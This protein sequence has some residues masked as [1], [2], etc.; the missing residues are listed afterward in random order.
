MPRLPHENLGG[1]SEFGDEPVVSFASI[2]PEYI[3]QSGVAGQEDSENKPRLSFWRLALGRR[4]RYS[5][6]RMSVWMRM[7]WGQSTRLRVR[8]G[9]RLAAWVASVGPMLIYLPGCSGDLSENLQSGQVLALHGLQGRWVG[10]VVPIDPGCGSPT[11][12]LMS[13]GE[14][15][16]GFDPFQSTAVI[17][18]EVGKDGRLAGS[19]AREGGEHRSLAITFEGLAATPD[20]INGTLQSSRCHWAVALHRG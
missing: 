17:R 14:N 15:G 13:I 11:R 16:F 2:M 12:G 9:F 20:A 4:H 7:L 10:S 18:G 8:K 19:L 3:P 1:E 6:E 5:A